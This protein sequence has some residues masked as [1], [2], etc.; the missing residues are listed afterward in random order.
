MR[1]LISNG[2]LI[3]MFLGFFSLGLVIVG[4]F[5]FR[6]YILAITLGYLIVNIVLWIVIMIFTLKEKKKGEEDV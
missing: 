3:T 6:E 2:L 1:N 5:L 4:W